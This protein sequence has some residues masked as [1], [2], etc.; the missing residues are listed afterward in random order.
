MFDTI[1]K[2]SCRSAK[3]IDTDIH[4]KP[5]NNNNRI[6]PFLF[7]LSGEQSEKNTNVHFFYL[8]YIRNSS[9]LGLLIKKATL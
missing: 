6:L 1:T 4:G 2:N 8:S 9:G 7:S 3:S 5:E